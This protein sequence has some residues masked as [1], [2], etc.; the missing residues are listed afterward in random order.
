MVQPRKTPK[1][2]RAKQRV[3]DILAA[4]ET[5][6]AN[7]GY[8][9]FSTNRVAKDANI[10]IASLYQYFPNKEALVYAINRKMLDEVIEGCKRYEGL[11]PTLSWE[12]LFDLMEKELITDTHHVKLVRALDYAIY[13]NEDLMA[14]ELE[15]EQRIA[16]FYARMFTFYG[17]K[18]PQ[19]SLLNSGRL[20]YKINNISYY[21][22]GHLSKED[23]QESLQI[24]EQHIKS[25]IEK[26]IN[27]PKP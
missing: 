22:L 10:N 14:M 3:A 25:L 7:E 2:A 9:N 18:W 13:T 24:Y 16:E 15:H 19:H 20:I 26:I 1:Q 12:Q 11:M 23:Q 5:L 4:A 6:L 21:D 17:S 27:Q 8:D